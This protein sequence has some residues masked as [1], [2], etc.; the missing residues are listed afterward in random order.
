MVEGDDHMTIDTV[1]REIAE[2]IRHEIGIAS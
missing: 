1:A 2:A